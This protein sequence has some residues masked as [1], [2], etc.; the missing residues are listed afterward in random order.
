MEKRVLL[1]SV[2]LM[3]VGLCGS[4]ALALDP[5]GPPAAGL[6]K[7]QFGAGAE[8]SY[9]EMDLKLSEGEWSD[10]LGSSGKLA[11]FTSKDVKLHKVYANLGYGITDNWEGFLRLGGASAD[12]KDVPWGQDEQPDGDTGF[13]IGFGTKVTFYEERNLKV[14]GLFQMSWFETEGRL[15]GIDEEGSSFSGSAETDITEIQIAVGPTYKLTKGL[16]IYGGPFFH[17]IDGDMKASGSWTTGPL[18]GTE[19]Y[20]YDIDEASCFGGYIGTAVDI[21]EN[22]S[23]NIEFQHTAAADALGISL[24]WRF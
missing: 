2:V 4:A 14:G 22:I 19:K 24:L 15:R 12:F 21:A 20:S 16:S 6:K 1:L 3:A 7:G 5:M 18:D 8:Y 9:S 23:C 13:A 17:F 10:N 11:S